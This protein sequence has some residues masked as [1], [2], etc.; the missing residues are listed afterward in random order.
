MVDHNDLF[1]NVLQTLHT[2]NK[3]HLIVIYDPLQTLIR[4]ANILFRICMSIVTR[5]TVNS[6]PPPLFFPYLRICTLLGFCVLFC[7]E[8]KQMRERD[9]DGSGK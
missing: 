8:R 1:L 7:F 2:W 3:S 4:N 9:I 6:S 5:D